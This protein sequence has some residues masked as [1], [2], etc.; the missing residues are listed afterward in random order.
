MKELALYF[1]DI[2]KNSTAAGARHV[3][4]SLSECEDGTLTA[5]ISDDG[6]GM[7]PDLL[8]AVSDPFT[9]TRTT[10]KVGMGIPLY[11]MAAEQ[12]GG[13]LSLESTLGAGT[14]ITAVFHRGHLDCP[15]LGDLPGAAAL[16]V[17]GSPQV[18]FTLVHTTVKVSYTFQTEQIRDLLGP[19]VPLD[20]PEVFLWIREFLA[21]QEANI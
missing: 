3:N 9:T 13:S 12:T 21:E 1:L 17:Q 8:A 18:D 2:V 6:K 11:R 10:R 19:E 15:P 14:T 7:S 4:L 5:V 16:M 20:T